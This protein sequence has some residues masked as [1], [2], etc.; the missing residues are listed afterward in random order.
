MLCSQSSR[1]SNKG[2]LSVPGVWHLPDDGAYR[3]TPDTWQFHAEDRDRAHPRSGYTLRL[4]RT[5]RKKTLLSAGLV[6]ARTTFFGRNKNKDVVGKS[7]HVKQLLET[8]PKCVL[9]A[10]SLLPYSSSHMVTWQTQIAAIVR[11]AGLKA[12]EWMDV[13][14]TFPAEMWAEWHVELPTRVVK[15]QTELATAGLAAPVPQDAMPVPR[16]FA[17]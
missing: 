8:K 14:L 5:W 12:E 6:C 11:I 16:H 17:S 2:L 7:E 4:C 3:D 10:D 13:D 9:C 15:S 1:R